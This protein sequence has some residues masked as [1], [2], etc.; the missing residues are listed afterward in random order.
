MLELITKATPTKPKIIIYGL[1]GC[2]DGDAEIR[3][4]SNYITPTIS[5]NI[6][7]KNLH[8]RFNGEKYV[9]WREEHPNEE[10]KVRCIDEETGLFEWAS[11]AGVFYSGEKET[12]KIKT[13]DYEIIATPDHQ[14]WTPSGWE[15]LENI[16][17][18]DMVGVSTVAQVRA[19][20]FQKVISITP[21]GVRPVYDIAC[22]DPHHSF[23]ANNF[24]VHNCGKSTLASTLPRPLFIDVEGGLNFLD[25]A[26]TKVM[27]NYSQT[28]KTIAEIGKN[29]EEYKKQFDT[30][31]IDSI[32]WLVRQAVEKTSGTVYVG[33]D[34]KLKRDLNAVL[35][36]SHGGFGNGKQVLENHIR[37]D[38]IPALRTLNNM[39]FIICLIAHAERKEL[40]EG[41]G[42]NYERIAPKIDPTTLNAFLEW[43]DDI[44]Y[45]KKD[46]S[47][48]RTLLLDSDDA[49]LAKN[50]VGATG[51]VTVTD[52]TLNEV[53]KL[54]KEK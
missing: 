52:N 33:E 50:R 34:L 16:K 53:L 23:I 32:D 39:G 37:A 5:K 43:C 30:I 7:L 12:V 40:M 15:K 1:S 14:F 13:D 49:A 3:V 4:R 36:K 38:L 9:G 29:A 18:G 19:A 25:V 21:M 11:V 51:E 41:D 46:A 47:G 45:L 28:V 6:K 31:V 22:A 17:A 35:G 54:N 42:T 48:T 10:F 8:K 27:S 26:R 20:V 24:V 2:I 44:F